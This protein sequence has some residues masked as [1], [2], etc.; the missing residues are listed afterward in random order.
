MLRAFCLFM[1]LL[2]CAACGRALTTA[3]RDFM[4]GIQGTTFDPAPVRITRN[5]LIGLNSVTYPVR[6]RTTCRERILPPAEG[7]TITGSTA[8]IVLFRTLHT[9]PAFF[10]DDY[11]LRRDGSVHLVAAMFF[12]HEMTHVWQWQ[13]RDVTDYHPA[14]AF[15]EHLSTQ[16]PYLFDGD[17]AFDFLEY[18]YEQQ[19]SLVEEYVCCRALDPNGAR[20]DRLEELL[21]VYMPINQHL[22]F[23]DDRPIQLPWDGVEIGGICA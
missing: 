5:P 18:G 11:I 12:A 7:P 14:R 9:R 8:G 15:A 20:T 16:D 22:S 6:P 13:N 23:L 19:A 4:A 3:E 10:L 21:G 1:L 2:A 17:S